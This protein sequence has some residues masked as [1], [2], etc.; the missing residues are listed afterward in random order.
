MVT[1][2]FRTSH[3]NSMQLYYCHLSFVSESLTASQVLY[4]F[5]PIRPVA[6]SDSEPMCELDY[7]PMLRI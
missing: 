6:S 3:G 2:I 1:Q 4:M 5:A 7:V